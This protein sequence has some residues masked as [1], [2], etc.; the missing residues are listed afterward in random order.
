MRVQVSFPVLI[1]CLYGLVGMILTPILDRLATVALFGPREWYESGFVP[2]WVACVLFALTSWW[3]RVP[4][5]AV[6]GLLV[7]G[8]PYGWYAWDLTATY[9]SPSANVAA[10]EYAMAM[11]TIVCFALSGALLNVLIS[12]AVGLAKRRFGFDGPR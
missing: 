8:P 5:P 4:R 9:L 3:I 10:L 12:N 1:G 7:T 6:Y 2:V 11:L